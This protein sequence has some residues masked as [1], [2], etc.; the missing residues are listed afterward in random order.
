MSRARSSVLLLAAVSALV[1][2]GRSPA[3]PTALPSPAIT[4]I[5]APDA[6]VAAGR[7]LDAWKAQ[8]YGAMYQRLSPLTQDAISQDEFQTRYADVW[9]TAALTGLDYEIVSSLVNPQAAQVRYRLNLHSAVFGDIVRET[10][11][12][13]TRA[14]DDW[15]VAWSDSAI[16]PELAGGNTLVADYITPTRANI[17]DRNGLGLATQT[18]AVALWIDTG[19]LGDGDAQDTMLRVLGRLLNRQ[20]DNLRA[21][22]ENY[23]EGSYAIP[24][25]EVSLEDFRSVQDTLASTGGVG[26]QEY[27]TRYYPSGGLAP[28]SVGYVSQIQLDEL[29]EKQ[30]QGYA[31][32]EMV[33]RTGLEEVYENE[34][35]GKPGGTLYVHNPDGQVVG[36]L[37]TVDPVIPQA[38]Y[39][40]LDRDLQRQAQDA[41]SGFRGAVVV[42]ERDTGRVLAMVSSPGFDPNLFD[43]RNPNWQ[44]GLS[45]IFQDPNSPTINRATLSSFPLGSVFKMVTM[46]AALESGLFHRDTIYNCLGEFTEIPGQTFYDWTVEEELPASGPLTLLEGLMRSCNPY[47]WHIGLALFDGGFPTAIPDMAK[48]FGFGQRT[49]IEIP[50]SAGL[51]P[52]PAWKREST[53]T[54]WSRED[55]MQLAIGQSA[56]NV[57]PLQVAR[58]IA[59]LGNGGTLYQPQLVER[60]QNAEGAVS[61][62]FAPVSQGKLPISAETLALVKEAMGMVVNSPRG[63]AYRRFLNFPITIYGKTGTAESGSENPHAWFAGYTDAGREGKPD[64]AVVVLAENAGQGAD[65]AAPIFRRVVEAYFFGQPYMPYPWESQIGVPKTPTP[66]PGAE[67]QATATPSP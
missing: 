63:T 31:G 46:S 58:Y 67:D 10:T 1:A 33:G 19:T 54:D 56:L 28:Q 9:R 3:S 64:I 16:L 49:G 53:G 5:A 8:D 57:T 48:G 39:T 61:H 66:T 21:L 47:F 36:S 32:D 38:V 42:L 6:E 20:P 22:Y 27:T 11:M 29:A 14:Q 23:P 43:T 7:F 18:D 40:T 35:R 41:I 24:L 50:D 4:S 25:G 65:I 26:W 52:D 34:L 51:V 62:Q 37:A 2:C 44:Y 30:A 60:I 13:L 17:Y 59:A 12:D 15:R 55:S 45:A